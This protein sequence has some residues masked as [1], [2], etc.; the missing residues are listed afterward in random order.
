[1]LPYSSVKVKDVQEKL[2]EDEKDCMIF[3]NNG[4]FVKTWSTILVS[5]LAYSATVM[6]Y[7]IAFY[8]DD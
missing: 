4:A 5:I 6:P 2:I 1:M 7:R 8:E 3:E